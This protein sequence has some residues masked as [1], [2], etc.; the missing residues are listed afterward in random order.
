MIF[1]ILIIA[2]L[3]AAHMYF[4]GV[5]AYRQWLSA[6]DM[7]RGLGKH[8]ARSFNFERSSFWADQILMADYDKHYWDLVFFRN[9]WEQYPVEIQ[10][11]LGQE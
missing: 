11:A 9:P 2:G 6:L 10:I 7:M 1:L 4:C 3:I 8:E 5:N